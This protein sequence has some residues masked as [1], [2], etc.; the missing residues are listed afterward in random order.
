LYKE[1]RTPFYRLSCFRFFKIWN[2]IFS[3]TTA[4]CKPQALNFISIFRI[5][6][7]LLHSYY[8]NPCFLFF[9]GQILPFFY[10]IIVLW[11]T[12]VT[13]TLRSPKMA[14]EKP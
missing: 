10:N 1:V 13:Q 9:C 14:V 6:S 3:P 5:I 7:T 4:I 2:T 8:T 11:A 12:P